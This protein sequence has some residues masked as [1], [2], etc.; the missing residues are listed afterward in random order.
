M[1]YVVYVVECF[2]ARHYYV[3]RVDMD[4]MYIMYVEYVVVCDEYTCGTVVEMS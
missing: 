3:C 4:V 1:V 2:Y